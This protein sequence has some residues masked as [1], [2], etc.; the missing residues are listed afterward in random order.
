VFGGLEI[1]THAEY[2]KLTEPNRQIAARQLVRIAERKE[3]RMQEFFKER[4][5]GLV[6]YALVLMLVVIVVVIILGVY[7]NQVTNLF[8]RVTSV[9]P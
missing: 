1:L 4:A 2:Y 9:M 6:E 8:S 5:Q 7:G 3:G